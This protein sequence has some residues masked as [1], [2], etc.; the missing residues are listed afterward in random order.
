MPEDRRLAAIMFTDIVGYTALMG[1]DED[2]AFDMLARNHTLHENLINKYNGTL[3]KEI[4][5]GTLASFPLASDAVRCAMDIQKEAKSQDIPLKIGIHQGEMVMAGADVLGDG[6]NV[7]SRLQEASREG[8][9]TISGKV[10]SD[11]KNKAGI[12]AKFIDDK[13]LKGVDDPVK[14]YEV[15]CE[16]EEETKPVEGE[17]VKSKFKTLYYIIAGIVV[18]LAAVIIWQFLPSK[19]SVQVEESETVT[20]DKSI[21]VLPFRNDSPDQENEYFCN[22]MVEAILTNLQK[23]EDLRVKSRTSVEQY[24]NPDKDLTIIARELKVAFIL[25]GSVQKVGDNIRITAQLIEGSTGDHL[26]ADN[27]DGKYTDEIFLF[28]SDVAKRVASSLQAVITPKEVERIDV[29]PTTNMLAYDLVMRGWK[30]IEK[31][32]DYR[33]STNLEL[34]MNLFN[35]ALEIDPNYGE[36][37]SSKGSVYLNRGNYDSAM[38]Y[39]EETINLYPELH[40]GYYHKGALFMGFLNQPDSAYEYIVK[41]YDLAP[42]YPWISMSLGQYY[43]NTKNDFIKALPYF[44]RAYDLGGESALINREIGNIYLEFGYYDVAERYY[45]QALQLSQ[46]CSYI[47]WFRFLYMLQGQY[48]EA[49]HFLDS[50]GNLTDCEQVCELNRFYFH[51]LDKDF[52]QAEQF[53]ERFINAG[54]TP[55]W[56]DSI[57]L[58]YVYK[59]QNRDQEASAILREVRNS[60]ESQISQNRYFTRIA[61]LSV[62][63]AMLDQKEESLKYLSEAADFNRWLSWFEYITKYPVYEKLWDDPE[64]KAI[65]KRSKDKLSAIRAQVREM[66]ER[67]ELDL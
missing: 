3:I 38:Y 30:M 6:V 63:Y 7:A 66:E 64:F 67:G 15:L 41:A 18:V 55:I 14:V 39:F 9:I 24:R 23:I 22:G 62:I 46:E 28:Q 40:I 12:T 26:W 44:Q 32:R 19:E 57:W 2:K 53:Y 59:E 16:K 51:S 25:E 49:L 33:D 13:K 58:A 36:A 5:D 65:V 27:Y 48:K 4:G 20:I 52:N 45:K 31:W 60:I 29:K 47:G 35:Q 56:V 54:G 11:I 34:A 50:I 21:A 10:Y 43:K 8:C 42:N 17:E 1:S 37:L 61:W